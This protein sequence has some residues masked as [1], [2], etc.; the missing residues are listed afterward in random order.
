MGPTFSGSLVLTSGSQGLKCMGTA[1]TLPCGLLSRTPASS[2]PQIASHSVCTSIW[3]WTGDPALRSAFSIYT[4]YTL[5]CYFPGLHSK[6]PQARWFQMIKAG[7]PAV[8]ET[9]SLKSSGQR[10][11]D[12]SA[13]TRGV[14]LFLC[15]F[16]WLQ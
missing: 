3:F 11:H 4:L 7:A 6:V 10:G 9:R 12:S 15:S 2:I 1:V 13:A 16:W 5:T 14:S 8:L